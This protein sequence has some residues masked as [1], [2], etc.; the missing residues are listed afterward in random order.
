MSY[1]RPFR[2]RRIVFPLIGVQSVP[3]PVAYKVLKP[4][5]AGPPVGSYAQPCDLIP[6]PFDCTAGEAKELRAFG[7][8]RLIDLGAIEPVYEEE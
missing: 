6:V 2:P 8:R 3:S 7:I 4:V 1:R 5:H